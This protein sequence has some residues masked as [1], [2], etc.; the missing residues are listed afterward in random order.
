MT[1]TARTLL[2]ALVMP[3][4]I[5]VVGIA[6][7][8]LAIPTLPDPI[9]VHWGP[10]GSPDGFGTPAAGIALIAIVVPAYAIFAL[11]VTRG[12]TAQSGNRS[13]VLAVSP[14]L[15]TV[16]TGVTAGS[17]AMQRGL[18]D[19]ADAPSVLPVLLLSLA[20]GA[21]LAVVSY[22]LLPA[23]QPSAD[24]VS[25]SPTL[26][27]SPTARAVWMRRVAPP[28]WLAI[29]LAVV[30]ALAIVG[31]GLAVGLYSPLP[32]LLVYLGAMLVA[33][34]LVGSSLFWRVTVDRS[35]IAARSLLGVPRFV[36]PLEQVASAS[37]V[38]VDPAREFGGWGMRWGGAGR[39]G[40]IL[41]SGEALEVRRA[42]GRSL[43]ITVDD[44][45]TA[46]ALLNS[47]RQ[48]VE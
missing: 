43:V 9:A 47:L 1:V 44:A 13:T 39:L 5:A 20:V 8:V 36:I 10:G 27:L 31:G 28:R 12:A 30:G 41:R 11:V 7:I 15:A 37:L 23:P 6:V 24:D 45:A 35:G 18:A 33:A 14:F 38:T 29:L 16:I 2:I 17:V 25:P 48:R 3:L 22:V 46:A 40:V 4:L 19:A 21:V 42:D 32:A 34:L 26:T